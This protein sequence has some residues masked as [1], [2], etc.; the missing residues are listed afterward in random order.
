MDKD[1]CVFS[2]YIF[3]FDGKDDK[4]YVSLTIYNKNPNS[5]TVAFQ[6]EKDFITDN[7]E[8]KDFLTYSNTNKYESFKILTTVTMIM[9]SF[10]IKN[11]LTNCILSAKDDKRHTVYK[12]M[13]SRNIKYWKMISDSKIDDVWIIEYD[14]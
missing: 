12:Y 8:D 3:K 4:Y 6:L 7:L 2:S 5:F 14:F 1:G 10:S 13:V 11:S 9:K